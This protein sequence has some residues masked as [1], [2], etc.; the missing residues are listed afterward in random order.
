MKSYSLNT[1]NL[2]SVN[3]C[4]EVIDMR[5][6]VSVREKTDK[7]ECRGVRLYIAN[8]SVPGFG[9]KDLAALNRLRNQ[10]CSLCEYLAG[11]EIIM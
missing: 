11:A 10:L 2:S 8:K 6:N 9:C 1:V 5:V 3:K 7:V 4:L